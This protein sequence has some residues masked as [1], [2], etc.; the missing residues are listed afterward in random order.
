MPVEVVPYREEWPAQFTLVAGRLWEALTDIPSARVEHVGSTAIPGLLVKPILDIDVIVDAD[1]MPGAV[2]ALARIGYRQR[3]HLGLVGREAFYPPDNDPR[4]NVYVCE[5]GS[6]NVRNHLAV[7]DVLRKRDD[8]RDRY[9][10]VKSALAA[11][12]SMDINTYIEG[13]TDVLQ[14]VLAESPL[15]TPA[16]RG[17]IEELNRSLPG[18]AQPSNAP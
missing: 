10:A 18:P 12:P 14:L 3:G 17:Q 6:L 15:V 4:R 8:L 16:E 11:D 9:A 2:L 1:A 7:R 13:K 5:A